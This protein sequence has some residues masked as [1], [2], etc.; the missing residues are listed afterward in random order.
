[1]HA[2]EASRDLTGD[3]GLTHVGAVRAQ[4]CTQSRSHRRPPRGNTAIRK[5]VRCGAVRGCPC[6]LR[7]GRRAYRRGCGRAVRVTVRVCRCGR[8]Q[9]SP[10]QLHLPIRKR[11]DSRIIV[12]ACM[13]QV[14]IPSTC[15]MR[16]ICSIQITWAPT[17]GAVGRGTV[18]DMARGAPAM[19]VCG[20]RPY[21]P[22]RLLAL[23]CKRR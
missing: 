15:C 21:P 7:A 16:A 19:R 13:P 1:M 10:V 22:C 4:I 23:S 6:I 14:C 12:A 2:C 3:G 18:E 11:H 20:S 5:G 17:H 9:H 8:V